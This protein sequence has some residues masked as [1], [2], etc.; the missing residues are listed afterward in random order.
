MTRSGTKN[1]TIGTMAIGTVSTYYRNRHVI[2]SRIAQ[3]RNCGN[4]L[5][6]ERQGIKSVR[7]NRLYNIQVNAIWPK[8][9]L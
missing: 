4:K 2:G 5:W 7:R 9:K 6:T 8:L 3:K 1:V